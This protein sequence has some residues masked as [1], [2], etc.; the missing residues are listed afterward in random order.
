MS[1]PN[2]SPG[3]SQ[4]TDRS[5]SAGLRVEQVLRPTL[6]P[7]DIV[8][9]GNLRAHKVAGVCEVIEQVGAWLPYLSPYAPDLSPI[10]P[11]EAQATPRAAY[12]RTREALEEAIVQELVCC[13]PYVK[14]R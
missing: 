10:E 6:R 1:C 5:F 11:C 4:R 13:S 3:Q 8:A 2:L 12:A 14:R 9:V 7:G